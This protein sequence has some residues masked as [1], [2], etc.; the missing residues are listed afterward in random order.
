MSFV[1]LKE[2]LFSDGSDSS[3]ISSS[4]DSVNMVLNDDVVDKVTMASNYD[5]IDK[6]NK[7]MWL[8]R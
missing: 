5:E 2:S 1:D 8:I 4:S 6:V 7:M 3:S